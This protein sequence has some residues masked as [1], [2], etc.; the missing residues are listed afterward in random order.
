[1]LRGSMNGTWGTALSVG[2]QFS[3]GQQIAHSAS[4][5]LPPSW[6]SQK[7]HVVAVLSKAGTKEV[8][9][10]EEAHIE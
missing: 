8:I 4:Y 5:T 9:Q 2:Q 10:A 6:N 1:V 3:A 7:V